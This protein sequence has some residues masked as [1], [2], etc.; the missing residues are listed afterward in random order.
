MR[1]WPCLLLCA[2]RVGAQPCPDAKDLPLLTIADVTD[3]PVGL[4]DKWQ[5]LWGDVPLSDG[6]VALLAHNDPLID[7]T[8][9]ELAHRPTWVFVGMG[10]GAIGMALS[11]AGWVSY[12]RNDPD[13]GPSV[14]LPMAGGGILLGLGGML[15]MTHYL[16]TPLEP[17][18]APTPEHR[19][20]RAEMREL[21]AT[22]NKR[23]HA[24]ICKA[25][26]RS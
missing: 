17:H 5:V 22:I 24:E 13:I 3:S 6:Q 16:Q 8:R 15:L 14:T 11:S 9:E 1:W 12:G 21:V 23:L 20:T 7:R 19:I 2:T 10:L 18:L 25:V 26:P 4:I